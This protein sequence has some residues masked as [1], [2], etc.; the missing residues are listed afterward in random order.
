ML[1]FDFVFQSLEGIWL[2]N[3][4]DNLFFI[5]IPNLEGLDKMKALAFPNCNIMLQEGRTRCRTATRIQFTNLLSRFNQLTRLDLSQ[6]SFAGCLREVLD[7]LSCPLQYLSL[8]ECDLIDQDII[9]LAKSKHSASLRHLDLSRICGLVPGDLFAVSTVTL[10]Q[11]LRHFTQLT[12]VQLRQNQITDSG[13]D[14]LCHLLTEHWHK[15]KSFDITENIIS[16]DSVLHIVQACSC[17]GIQ[18]L[19]LPHLHN[20]TDNACQHFSRQVKEVLK[21]CGRL[22]IEA[23]ICGL[24]DV[25]FGHGL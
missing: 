18:H 21:R 6:N 19:R 8:C 22:D 25:G 10:L 9:E 5:T 17:T 3:L 16:G 7:A 13:V 20:F 4:E 15:L 24:L 14:Q 2:E 11:N 23:E 1:C 12:V